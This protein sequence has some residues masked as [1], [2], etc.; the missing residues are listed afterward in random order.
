MIEKDKFRK[1]LSNK[2]KDIDEKKQRKKKAFENLL[3]KNEARRE[4]EEPLDKF[5]KELDSLVKEEYERYEI[6]DDYLS[7]GLSISYESHF[8]YFSMGKFLVG[9]RGDDIPKIHPGYRFFAW[10]MPSPFSGKNLNN[11]EVN[12]LEYSGWPDGRDDKLTSESFDVLEDLFK[13]LTKEICD[14]LAEDIQ[15]YKDYSKLKIKKP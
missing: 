13:Y 4:K 2:L 15:F 12:K 1:T 3:K 9:Y 7:R 11:W 5:L 10:R 14:L 6:P 8:I